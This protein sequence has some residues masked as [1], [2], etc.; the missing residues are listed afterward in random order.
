MGVPMKTSD[1]IGLILFGLMLLTGVAA[2]LNG[3]QTDHEH[4]HYRTTC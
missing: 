4:C 1:V 2:A 3:E